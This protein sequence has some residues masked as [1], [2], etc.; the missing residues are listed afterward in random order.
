MKYGIVRLPLRTCL[1]YVV[2]LCL[3]LALELLLPYRCPVPL[4]DETLA[5][6]NRDYENA[7]ILA[8]DQK[9]Q[10]H[11]YL[12]QTQ[13]GA[14]ALVSAQ[15]HSIFFNHCRILAN[16]TASVAQEAGIQTLSVKKGIQTAIVQVDAQ[17]PEVTIVNGLAASVNGQYLMYFLM[18]GALTVLAEILW[19]KLRGE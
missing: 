14:V 8:S 7:T 18:A 12:V 4:T 16:K 19:L 1:T 13:D 6:A 11:C 2:S 17:A 3:I 9:G 10:L 15:T 5:L